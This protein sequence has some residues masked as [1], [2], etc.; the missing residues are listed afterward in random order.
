MG[1]GQMTES[2]FETLNPYIFIRLQFIHTPKGYG[3]VRIQSFG[4][5]NQSFAQSGGFYELD[6]SNHSE[7]HTCRCYILDLRGTYAAPTH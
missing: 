5:M 3:N 6:N 4:G 2:Y 1:K 7:I